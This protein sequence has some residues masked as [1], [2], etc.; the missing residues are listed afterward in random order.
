L[1]RIRSHASKAIRRIVMVGGGAQN[2][3]LRRLTAEKTGLEVIQGPAESS[4]IGNLAVQM[5]VLEER[6][7]TTPPEFASAIAAWAGVLREA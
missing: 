5:A 3:T 2:A 4:T 6:L 7:S 1:D